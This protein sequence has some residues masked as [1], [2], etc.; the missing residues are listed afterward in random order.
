MSKLSVLL[1]V[2]LCVISAPAVGQWTNRTFVSIT[3]ERSGKHPVEATVSFLAGRE[4]TSRE[5]CGFYGRTVQE[6]S[7]GRIKLTVEVRRLDPESGGYQQLSRFVAGKARVRDDFSVSICKTKQIELEPGDKIVF[8][9]R[10]S[11]MPDFE[12][13]EEPVDGLFGPVVPRSHTSFSFSGRV[14]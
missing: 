6:G 13:I 12:Y 7:K 3:A 10:F 14:Q 8:I 5:F 4:F 11:K 9:A 2:A 1:L